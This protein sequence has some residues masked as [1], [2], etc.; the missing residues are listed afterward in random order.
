M[1]SVDSALKDAINLSTLFI[2]KEPPAMLVRGEE[3]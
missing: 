1:K 3:L 2:C